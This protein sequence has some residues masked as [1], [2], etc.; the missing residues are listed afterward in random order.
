[1]EKAISTIFEAFKSSGF[2]HKRHLGEVGLEIETECKN[3]YTPPALKYWN[4][5][6]DGSLRDFGIE[7]IL[8][9]PVDRDRVKDVLEEWDVKVNKQFKLV[10][11]SYT[12]SVH[13]HLNF[14]NDTWLTLVNF[15]TAY[16]LVEN[17]LIKFSGPDRL[18]NLF[19]LPICDAENQLSPAKGLFRTI[20]NLQYSKLKLPAESYKYSALNL[21]NLTKLGTME[22]RSMRGVMD[23]KVIQQWVNLIT[24]IKD[25]AKTKGLTPRKILDMYGTQGVDIIYH[26]FGD[27]VDLIKY[28]NA[29]ELIYKNAWYAAALAK[30][31]NPQDE[32]WGFPKP[33]K[34]YKEQQ[35]EMLESLSQAEYKS[36]YISLPYH[37]KIMIDEKLMR[38]LSLSSREVIFMEGDF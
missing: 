29:E 19:C 20:S 22:V 14:L 34:V 30:E 1:M 21:C 32:T 33:K 37:L 12:T 4:H 27:H 15:I 5:V 24:S 11:D 3:T 2:S 8:N 16:Y 25:F 17:L 7:Y 31:V 6:S 23:I 36:P 26:I 18:S 35:L 9:G 38:Q 13:I 28:A 10:K